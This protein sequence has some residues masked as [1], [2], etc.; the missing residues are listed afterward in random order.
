M[1]KKKKQTKKGK[2]EASQE[3]VFWPLAG[4]VL[5]LVLAFLLLLGGFGTGGPLPKNLFHGAYWAFGWAAYLTIFAC[6]LWGVLKFN[7]EDR[8]IPFGKVMSML[9]ALLFA[10]A[11]L[12]TMFATA[13][14]VPGG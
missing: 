12:H 1:A 2:A 10:S 7:A 11:W 3:S 6:A 8:K 14:A 9:V 5:L 13:A 4:G